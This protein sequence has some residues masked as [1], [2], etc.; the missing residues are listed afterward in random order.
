MDTIIYFYKKRGL[1]EPAI[2]P[3]GMKAY[4]LVRVAL[5]VGKEE[6]FGR[7]IDKAEEEIKGEGIAFG[8]VMK[9]GDC[10]GRF[11]RHP[12]QAIRQARWQKSQKRL[13]GGNARQAQIRRDGL[14]AEREE[15]LKGIK[16]AMEKLASEVLEL[17]DASGE[18]FCVYED[19]V[20]KELMESESW[21]IARGDWQR[22]YLDGEN[23]KNDSRQTLSDMW[24]SCFPIPEF[25][26]YGQTFW[27]GRLLPEATLPHFVILGTTSCVY[28]LI[29]GL[30]HRMKSL[31]WILLEKDCNQEQLDFAEDFYTEY[32]LAITLETLE[33]EAMYR[34]LRLGCGMSVNV[35][36]FTMETQVPVWE[37]AEGS[38]W[39]D[40]MSVEEKRRRIQGR[41]MGI[42]YFSLKE[43]WR[44]AQKRCNCPIFP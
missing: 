17:A 21:A 16:A 15:R 31:R 8:Q 14:L 3:V 2:E 41:G 44:H 30:A 37:M 10:H 23:G 25:A 9:P 19:G 35:I 26:G 27:M 6:W 12:I 1:K 36:D 18:C 5:D 20:R 33:S 42:A 24:R 38:V 7:K 11:L 28:A 43:E 39:L 40:M 22:A 4:M 13:A 29:E 34:R 32:G